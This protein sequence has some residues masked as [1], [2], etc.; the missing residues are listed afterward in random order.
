MTLCVYNT[1]LA[2]GKGFVESFG[3]NRLTI[4]T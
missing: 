4:V 2:V 1:I 3:N